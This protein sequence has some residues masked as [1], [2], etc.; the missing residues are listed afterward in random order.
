MLIAITII[1]YMKVNLKMIKLMEKVQNT[2]EKQIIKK[3]MES[4]KSFHQLKN[5][6]NTIK[7]EVY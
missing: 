1:L 6:K 2:M 5:S 4:F 3:Q 7:M